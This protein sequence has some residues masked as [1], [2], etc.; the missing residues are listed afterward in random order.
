VNPD[1]VDR[2]Y[3]CAASDSGTAAVE[4]RWAHIKADHARIA[5][6]GRQSVKVLEPGILHSLLL[7][8]PALPEKTRVRWKALQLARMQPVKSFRY[9][10]RSV[11]KRVPPR[12]GL[13]RCAPKK[14]RP[15]IETGGL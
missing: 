5:S 9:A 10:E 7:A 2:H 14:A 8:G 15:L 4:Q 11:E 12:H 1:E 3:A 6:D 13:P